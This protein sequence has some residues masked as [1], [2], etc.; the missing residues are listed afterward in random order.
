MTERP[1]TI[2]GLAG[3]SALGSDV[4]EQ[5]AAM[6]AH[7]TSLRPLSQHPDTGNECPDLLAGWITDRSWLSGRKYGGASNASVRAARAAVADAGWTKEQLAGCHVFSGTSRGNTGELFGK[8]NA[9]DPVR[10]WSTSNSMHSETA[11]AVSVELGIRGPWTTLSNGCSSGLDALALAFLTLSSGAA[12]RALVIGVDFPLMPELLRQYRD[13]GILSTNNLNDP[14]S[15]ATSGMLPAEAVAAIA[16]EVSTR[17]GPVILATAANS[18]AFDHVGLPPA[19]RPS[20]QLIES[21]LAHPAIRER[22]VSA[23][24]PHASGTLAHGVAEQAALTHVFGQPADRPVSLHLV[25]PFTGHS[26]GACGMIDAVLLC[27]FL[28][29]G[30]LPPNLPG[31]STPPGGRFLAPEQI[32]PFDPAT[33]LLKI[34]AGM[35]GRNTIVAFG[36]Q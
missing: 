10:K 31:L 17:P 7:K 23:V 36:V 8:W 30:N 34:A 9:R 33:S 11:S 1:V 4:A 15:P 25:K 21:T 26:L 3:A 16:L 35:G 14:Y 24:C 19:G 27:A 5:Q 28:R 29:D 12:D 2:T 6:T 32:R 13:T 18:D 22:P 20:I